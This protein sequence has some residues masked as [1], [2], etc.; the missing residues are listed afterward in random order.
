MRAH[1][2]A[3]VGQPPTKQ[4]LVALLVQPTEPEQA[5]AALQRLQSLLKTRRL[6]RHRNVLP[7]HATLADAGQ[8]LAGVA[9]LRPRY[10]FADLLRPDARVHVQ[11]LLDVVA[12]VAEAL[13]FLS[14]RRLHVEVQLDDVYATPAY[15]AKLLYRGS[16]T[17]VTPMDAVQ[18]FGRLLQECGELN[19][20]LKSHASLA[21]MT[22]ASAG[23]GYDGM[24]DLAQEARQVWWWGGG[25][26]GRPSAVREAKFEHLIVVARRQPFSSPLHSFL[27]TS[28]PAG[29][30]TWKR[31]G[32]SS[33]LSKCWG[34][35]T[36]ERCSSWRWIPLGRRRSWSPSR[37]C[38]MRLARQDFSALHG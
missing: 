21:L 20:A 3:M 10:A 8:P 37:R 5:H 14:V 18:A 29:A 6:L 12:G 9:F 30:S 4:R 26:L 16:R 32:R 1:G 33:H 34:R 13:E 24:Q 28:F 35:A 38:E 11:S 27:P 25:G 15:R 2:D 22:K 19:A 7:V 23:G 31:A 36:L 17:D